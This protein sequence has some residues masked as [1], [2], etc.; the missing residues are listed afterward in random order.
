MKAL[1]TKFWLFATLKANNVSSPD[2]TPAVE[3]FSSVPPCEREDSATSVVCGGSVMRSG[4]HQSNQDQG[5]NEN[6]G[7]IGEVSALVGSKR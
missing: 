3:S 7:T 6:G 5:V 1:Y 2:S 4:G